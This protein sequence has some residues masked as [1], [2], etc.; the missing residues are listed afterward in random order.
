ME[1]VSLNKIRVAAPCNAEWKWMYGT[2][3]VRFCPQ[4][5]QNVYNLSAMTR[6]EA[7]LLIL[8]NEERLCARFYRRKDGTIITR[9]CPVGLQGIRD[10]WTG[11]KARI[12][13]A[14]LSLIGYTAAMVGWQSS[15]QDLGVIS[16]IAQRLGHSSDGGMMGAIAPSSSYMPTI[17]RSE[18][19][20]RKR[21]VSKLIPIF[22]QADGSSVTGLAIVSIE[23]SETGDVDGVSFIAGPEAVR[24]LVERAAGAWTFTPTV[25]RGKPVRVESTLSFRFR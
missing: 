11:A 4:C 17:S 18:H 2:D 1:R 14:V 13:A 25:L 6:E 22:H 5:S 19:F 3:R 15:R 7:E 20:M 23:V 24:D 9:N 8:R 12:V 10:K 16:V 21:A